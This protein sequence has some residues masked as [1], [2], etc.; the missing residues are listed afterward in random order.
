VKVN[1]NA[2]ASAAQLLDD[3][4]VR[5]DLADQLIHLE[6]VSVSWDCVVG[7]ATAKSTTRACRPKWEVGNIPA[8]V[9]HYMVAG[10]SELL[11]FL[12]LRRAITV[13]WSGYHMRGARDGFASMRTY[14]PPEEFLIA[15]T[16]I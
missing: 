6:S 16:S 7:A 10:G 8:A 15:V 2:H 14:R 3:A 5:D 4:V 1:H 11:R 12:R 13:N 9:V